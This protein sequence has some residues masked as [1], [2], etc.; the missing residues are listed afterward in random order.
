MSTGGILE[1]EGGNGGNYVG[2]KA[3]DTGV[4]AD[5]VWTLPSVDGTAG[6]ALVTDGNAGLTWADVPKIVT[7]DPNGGSWMG[8]SPRKILVAPYDYFYVVTAGIDKP[9]SMLTSWNTRADGLG[10]SLPLFT[11][12]L[13]NSALL[14]IPNLTLYAQWVVGA[15]AG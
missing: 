7:H 15:P 12:L 8:E 1:L 14:A 4:T 9:D 2:L 3:A 13:M 11:A 6:Q 5:A 10:Y